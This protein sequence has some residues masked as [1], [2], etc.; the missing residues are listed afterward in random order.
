MRSTFLTLSLLYAVPA[1]AIDLDL[2]FNLDSKLLARELAHQEQ[3][4]AQRQRAEAQQREAAAQAAK[5]APAC[6]PV[7]LPAQANGGDHVFDEK[8]GHASVRL[9]FGRLLMMIDTPIRGAGGGASLAIGEDCRLAAEPNCK[10]VF[11]AESGGFVP[12]GKVSANSGRLTFALQDV[13]L[14][15]WKTN[16][17]IELRGKVTVRANWGN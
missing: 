17:C 12:S 2:N 5:K 7:E 14:R 11:R 6:T 3:Q 8:S 9:V 10:R 1:L 15:S 4:R 16:E 13:V